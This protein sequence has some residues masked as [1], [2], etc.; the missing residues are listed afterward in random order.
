MT[1]TTADYPI[2]PERLI[3]I[4]PD[5]CP[6]A[7]NELVIIIDDSGHDTGKHGRFVGLET[8]LFGYTGNGH[9]AIVDG[10]NLMIPLKYLRAV[11]H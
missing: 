9:V 10:P 1:T 4:R 8:N 5:T 7:F 11:K 2:R 3:E 6:F